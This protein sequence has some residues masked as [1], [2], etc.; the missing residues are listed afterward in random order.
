[1]KKLL[2]ILCLILALSLT[3]TLGFYFGRIEKKEPKEVE[4][5]EVKSETIAICNLDEG[6]KDNSGNIT[7]YAGAIIDKIQ[8]KY[9]NTSL[10]E[11]ENGVRSGKYSAYVIM[12][13][14]FSE[15]FVSLNAN[16]QKTTIKYEINQDLTSQEAIK[17]MQNISS[18]YESVEN[19]MEKIYL[20][21]ILAE[22]HDGQ[23]KVSNVLKRDKDDLSKINAIMPSSLSE[24]IKLPELKKIEA[25]NYDLDF[26]TFKKEVQENVDEYGR[27]EGEYLLED[28][29]IIKEK[30]ATFR[31]NFNDIVLIANVGKEL[32]EYIENFS[33][34][35]LIDSMKLGALEEEEFNSNLK[36]KGEDYYIDGVLENLSE[37]E[38]KEINTIL[39]ELNK[40][41]EEI[42]N[43]LNEL[44]KIEEARNQAKEKQDGQ[45]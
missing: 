4:K 9:E 10:N 19:S 1:M 24:S 2:S 22:F 17:A 3:L 40:T 36:I 41:K 20:S 23:N 28:E 15:A 38:E 39:D 5:P 35:T 29:A 45:V 26:E 7:N 8:I 13:S 44:N 11:A 34:E 43:I 16:P 6:V 30:I 14:D 42:D 25:F 33:K 12:P 18:I 37:E 31:E 27:K 32:P 21:S